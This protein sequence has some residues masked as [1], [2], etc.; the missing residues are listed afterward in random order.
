TSASSLATATADP[1]DEPPGTSAGSKGF[2]GVPY[3]ALTPVAPKASS[4]RLAFPTMRASAARAP[5]MQR[6][7]FSAGAAASATA[8]QPAVVGTPSTSMR[9]LTASLGPRPDESNWAMNVLTR[10]G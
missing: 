2:T 3:Q 8:R 7:S 1:L 9:S 4:W 10:L 6:A 5:A